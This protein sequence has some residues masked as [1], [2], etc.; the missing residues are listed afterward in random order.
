[1]HQTFLQWN[2]EKRHRQYFILYYTRR[3]PRL[4]CTLQLYIVL[5]YRFPK[6]KQARLA[7]WQHLI[8]SQDGQIHYRNCLTNV[9]RIRQLLNSQFNNALKRS[10]PC[11]STERLGHTECEGITKSCQPVTLS[12]KWTWQLKNW[13]LMPDKK[14]PT[15]TKLCCSEKILQEIISCH[16]N[17]L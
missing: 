14:R 17:L 13:L 2:E 16:C 12:H 7:A 6:Q 4:V 10:L 15:G 3:R 9:L 8:W 5:F 1:M 11:E